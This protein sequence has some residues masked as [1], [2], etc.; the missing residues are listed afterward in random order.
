MNEADQAKF[1]RKALPV[2]EAQTRIMPYAKETE[3]EIVPLPEALGRILAERVTAPHPYPHFRRSGMD[4]FAVLS[5]DTTGCHAE[6]PVLLEVVDE[7]PAGSVPKVKLTSGQAARIMTGA[8]VPDVADA[9]VMFEMTESV[10][11]EDK[12]YIRLIREIEKGKNITP[13]GL[14]LSQGDVILEA[15]RKLSAG[16]I[17]VLATFGLHQVPV[18]KR[19][20]IAV[21][22]TGSELLRIDEPLQ[23]G[24]IRNSNT[25]MLYS[26]IIEAG[27]EPILFDAIE[28][29]LAQAKAQ[30]EAAFANYDMV[31]TTGGV[32]VGDYDIMADLVS[33][34]SVDML[35]NKVTMRPGS[36]TTAA[37]KDGKLLF[38][39]S[40]NPG[41]CFVGFELFARPA[42]GRMMGVPHPFLPELT[43]ELARP[44]GKINNFT[45]FVRGRLEL[46]D[47]KLYAI[48]AELDESGVMITIKDS[49]ALII[50]PPSNKGMEAGVQVR[51]LKLPGGSF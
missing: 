30:V 14:E 16:E 4:G 13:V 40:G 10:V 42:I 35:F 19:P 29:D 49:D 18:R 38:A 46:R 47:G 27:G 20:R 17:S 41:A 2:A 33:G 34:G 48:P 6:Q 45:R 26:Q 24:R 25:Y 39:L 15:G 22:S 32:S 36:V 37:V 7:I 50:I 23:D 31:V 51:V 21:F 11:Q 3:T 43:A 9:V 8:K 12:T 44:Y 1:R 28:D 5:G